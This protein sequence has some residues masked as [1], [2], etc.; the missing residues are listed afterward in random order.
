MSSVK[1]I[2]IETKYGKEIHDVSQDALDALDNWAFPEGVEHVPGPVDEYLA[3]ASLPEL[4]VLSA[5]LVRRVERLR[6]WEK[7]WK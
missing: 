1:E 7:K 2:V 4:E 3:K 6:I 5:A